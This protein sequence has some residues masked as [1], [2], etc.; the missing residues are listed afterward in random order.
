M[1]WRR[2][3]PE[4]RATVAALEARAQA[5][6][7]TDAAIAEELGHPD[8][9]VVGSFDGDVLQAWLGLRRMVDELWVLNIATDPG[10]RRR[11][12]AR[13]LLHEARRIAEEQ[14]CTAL[15]LEVRASNA[16]ARA[17]YESIGFIEQG[18]RPG[19]YPGLAP[20]DP[21]HTPDSLNE[22]RPVGLYPRETAILYVLSCDEA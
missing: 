2:L 20:L 9:I 16:H 4:D 3:R 18:R 19:Y 10:L 13:A 7:W 22:A 14:R 11:G 17:L 8:A 12:L 21:Q 15:W 6:P 5:R 1:I